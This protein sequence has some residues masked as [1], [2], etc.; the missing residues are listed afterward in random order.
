MRVLSNSQALKS[1]QQA[2]TKGRHLWL[3]NKRCC[4][5][6]P[7]QLSVTRGI[8]FL[9][10]LVWLRVCLVLLLSRTKRSATLKVT[11]CHYWLSLPGF[12]PFVLLLVFL[13][14][15]PTGGCFI[16]YMYLPAARPGSSVLCLVFLNVCI[17]L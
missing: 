6:L 15:I 12:F 13:C 2:C 4:L 5:M 3:A 14:T 11:F 9:I 16:Q 7:F 17:L 1:F 10:C 8:F